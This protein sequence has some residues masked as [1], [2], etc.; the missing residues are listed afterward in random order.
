MAVNSEESKGDI[1]GEQHRGAL[2]IL[3]CPISQA[4]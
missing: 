3:V 4:G 1:T 2:K